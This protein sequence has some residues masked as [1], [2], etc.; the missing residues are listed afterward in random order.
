[1]FSKPILTQEYLDQQTSIYENELNTLVANVKNDPIF[2]LSSSLKAQIKNPIGELIT[3]LAA[4]NNDSIPDLEMLLDTIQSD[5]NSIDDAHDLIL[6]DTQTLNLQKARDYMK[7]IQGFIH[8]ASSNPN[9]YSPVG[10]NQV[11]N[12]FAKNHKDLFKSDWEPLPEIDSDYAMLYTMAM[13]QYENTID[14]WMQISDN[15]NVNKIR[16]FIA[17]DR[18]FHKALFESLKTRDLKVSFDDKEYDLLQGYVETEEDSEIKLF[19]IEQAIHDN[20]QKFLSE[21]K[22]S[23]SEFLEK[24]QLLTKLIPSF[25]NLVKQRVSRLSSSMTH[26]TLTDF[27]MLQ[28]FA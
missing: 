22:L 17:T 19:N 6:D 23:I 10:H 16:Q 13:S 3:A 9:K 21:S 15:N 8:A 25:T 5:F 12:E 28:Y 1:M 20:F 11:I 14:D 2:E 4:K 27:D 26:E 24:S 7:L 18:A